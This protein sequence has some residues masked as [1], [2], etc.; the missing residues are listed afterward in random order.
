M[1]LIVVRPKNMQAR[2]SIF[3]TLLL[4]LLALSLL[5][6]CTPSTKADDKY[7]HTTY[8]LA[9]AAPSPIGVGQTIYLTYLIENVPPAVLPTNNPKFYYWSG[10]T[11]TITQPDGTVKNVTGLQTSYAGAGTYAYVPT[12]AGNYSLVASYAGETIPSGPNAG[13]IFLPSTSKPITFQVQTDPIP[14]PLS[15]PLPSEYWTFPIE[16]ENQQWFIYSGNWLAGRFPAPSV[17][18]AYNPYTQGPY[19][20]HVMW[21]IPWTVGG[22]VGGANLAQQYQFG[23]WPGGSDQYFSPYIANGIMYTNLP[24]YYPVGGTTGAGGGAQPAGFEAIELS[25]GKVLWKQTA[26]NDSLTCAEVL[27][28][29]KSTMA[30]GTY[31]TLWNTAGT[32]W[33]AYDPL[34]GNLVQTITGAAS[35]GKLTFGPNGELMI[36]YYNNANGWLALWNS[37]YFESAVAQYTGWGNNWIYDPNVVYVVPQG[38]YN[39][40]L[41]Y[42]WNITIPKGLGS[43]GTGTFPNDLLI[44]SSSFAATNTST[45]AIQL[46]AFSIKPDQYTSAPYNIQGLGALQK[47]TGNQSAQILWGPTNITTFIDNDGYERID[48]AGYMNDG[49]PIFAIYP[50][51]TLSIDI[52]NAKTGQKISST[53]PFTSTFASFSGESNNIQIANGKLYVCG[54]DGTVHAFDPATGKSVWKYYVGDAGTTTPYGTWVLEGSYSYYTITADVLYVGANEHSPANPTWLG[55][56]I[57]AVNATDGTL[58]WKIDGIQDETQPMPAYGN[59]LVFLNFYDGK[60]YDIGKGPSQTTVQAPQTQVIAGQTVT[61]TGSVLDKSPGATQTEQVA[62]FPNGLPCI[63]DASM[64]DWMN[65]VYMQKP[66]PTNATGVE[67]TLTAIDPNHNYVTLGTT[68]TDLNGNYAFVWN[69]PQIDGAYQ[70]IATFSGTNSYWG[71]SNTA[72]ANLVPAPTATATTNTVSGTSIA[73]QYFIPAFVALLAVMVI[74]FA[75]LYLAL[76]KRP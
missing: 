21:S 20:A 67:V 50:R 54:Y 16:S 71:S 13:I 38:T 11:L 14:A 41:G 28:Y 74:G 33:R 43:I 51:Q 44:T 75:V 23:R 4:V 24:Q 31:L 53:E 49:T 48:A 9:A 1:K 32:T 55:G 52:Y 37:T 73:D 26:Y 29:G 58:L 8:I 57:W 2:N 59:Q 60:L 66:K 65:Y 46:T 27:N 35:G 30:Q 40:S 3:A 76:R 63:S 6:V 61:I 15:Y 72:Y 19:S 64:N 17:Q 5:A 18:N 70:I 34:T 68:T 12:E 62:R 10:V 39:F 36:Y 25:T 42:Q 22:L 47:T 56:Q 69:T 7:H 45:T